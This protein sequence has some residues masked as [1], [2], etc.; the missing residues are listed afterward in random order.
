MKRLI[1][2]SIYNLQYEKN[3]I[4]NNFE[5]NKLLISTKSLYN[6]YVDFLSGK[7]STTN[8]PLGI[9][10]NSNNEFMLVDG[11]HRLIELLL[12]STTTSD[13]KIWGIGYSDYWKDI[14]DPFNIDF[15]LKWNG[16]EEFADEECL[17][18]DYD[19]L[20]L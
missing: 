7:P 16:L 6:A 18:D 11:Y 3:D 17:Q 19:N 13:I 5:I 9:W 1:K 2:K 4:I 10:I 15:N 20:F 14:D 12:K 8:E